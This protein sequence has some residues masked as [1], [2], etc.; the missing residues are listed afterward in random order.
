MTSKKT[1]AQAE[2]ADLLKELN[3]TKTNIANLTS[4][5]GEERAA[6]LVAVKH[7]K[8]ALI[9]IEAAIKQVTAFFKKNKI[10]VSLAQEKQV[11][12]LAQAHG[13]KPAPD[14][15]F[16]DANYKG[17]KDSTKAVVAMMGMVKEDMQKE[18]ENGQQED[19]KNQEL[20]EKDF[21]ALKELL[22]TQETKE[23]SLNKLLAELEGAIESK[24]ETNSTKTDERSSELEEKDNLAVNCEWIKTK[25]GERRQK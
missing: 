13:S 2:L 25:F 9:L 23:I 14:A 21:S 15:G 19:A 22:E 20:Y 18:I 10:S 17:G 11:S 1:E 5:R 4:E 3:G 7:D 16:K 6:F 12:L 24:M 8:E